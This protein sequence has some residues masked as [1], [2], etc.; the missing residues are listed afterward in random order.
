MKPTDL[1]ESVSRAYTEALRRSREQGGGCCGAPAPCCDP[2]AT[3][4]IASLA[5]YGTSAQAY[6]EAAGS[7]F[8]CGNPLAFAEVRPGQ[9]VVDLGSGAGL[10][11]LLAA[12]RVGPGGRVIGVDM[13][14][15]MIEA[16]RA[17]VTAAGHTHVEVR[18]GLI[19]ALPLPA[20]SAD[21]V[22]SNCVIN[23]SPDKPKVFSEIFRILAPGGRFAISDIVVEALPTELRGHAAAYAAC[24]AGAISE[25]DYL[26]GLRAAGLVD[27]EVEERLVYDAEQIRGIIASDLDDLGGD[28][29]LSARV[30]RHLPALAGKV[31]SARFTGGKPRP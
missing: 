10:D 31:W 1:H 30:D 12:E 9:T 15:A 19:E 25:A 2:T 22:I 13:T 18:E 23:L 5:G 7:S 11:L 16:A 28:A 4:A 3:S 14:P 6:A 21:W 24:V 26:A 27:V 17:S 29:C 8:G 20:G